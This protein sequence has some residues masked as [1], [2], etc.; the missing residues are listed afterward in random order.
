[1]YTIFSNLFLMIFLGACFRNSFQQKQI[2][3]ITNKHLLKVPVDER[4]YQVNELL[5]LFFKSK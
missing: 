4:Y 5:Q 1:M 2:I 3:L